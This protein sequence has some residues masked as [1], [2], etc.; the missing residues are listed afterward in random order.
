MNYNELD[1]WRKAVDLVVEIYRVTSTFPKDETYGLVAQMRRAAV[2]IPSNIAEGQG[3]Y[4]SREDERFALTARGSLLELETQVVIAERLGY[5]ETA[6]A[7]GLLESA[8]EV[9]RLLNGF[10]RYLRTL[11]TDNR[12]PTTGNQ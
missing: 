8:A 9:G 12:Q 6:K 4:S 5:L 7:N 3:R 10:V 1:V 11:T 2:S